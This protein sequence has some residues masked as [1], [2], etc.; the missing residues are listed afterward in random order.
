MDTESRTSRRPTPLFLALDLTAAELREYTN[1]GCMFLPAAGYSLGSGWY[2]RGTTGYYWSGT[3]YVTSPSQANR[4]GFTVSQLNVMS[5]TRA[6][7][8]AAVPV[9]N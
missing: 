7:Y 3:I 2:A 9:E 8:L 4:F 5:L 6:R 1:H